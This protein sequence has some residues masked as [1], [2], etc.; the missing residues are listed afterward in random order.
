MH[1]LHW[2]L[3]FMFLKEN[4]VDLYLMFFYMQYTVNNKSYRGFCDDEMFCYITEIWFNLV[5]YFQERTF[6]RKFHQSIIMRNILFK[7]HVQLYKSKDQDW[8]KKI[9]FNYKISQITHIQYLHQS[10]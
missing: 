2:I 9:E 4:Y 1:V 6:D 7:S 3:G 10:D 8:S 5:Y